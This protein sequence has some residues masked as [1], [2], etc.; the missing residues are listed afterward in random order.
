M[1]TVRNELLIDVLLTLPD[2]TTARVPARSR[3]PVALPRRAVALAW[4]AVDPGAFRSPGLAEDVLGDLLRVPSRDD[5]VVVSARTL[6]QPVFAP[7]I[8]N[9]G[10]DPIRV[11]VNVGLRNASGLS[12]EVECGCRIEPGAEEEFIGYYRAYANSGVRVI[13]PD[14]RSSTFDE[15]AGDASPRSGAIPLRVTRR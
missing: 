8:S 15:V 6:A 10:T 3:T 7:M 14:G 12:E 11:I 1:V 4:N 9:R 2:R 13:T 5:S